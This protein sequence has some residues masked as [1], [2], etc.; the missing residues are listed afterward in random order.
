M[1]KI[2]AIGV[3]T[4]LGGVAA[5]QLALVLGAPWGAHVYG[6]RVAGPGEAL[7]APYRVASV[8][9]IGLLVGAG[10][11]VLARAGVVAPDL[12]ASALVLRGTWVVAVYLVLNTLANL[13][14]T[15]LVERWALGAATAA[16]AVMTVLVARS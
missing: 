6:G 4:I 7:P 5:M 16:A 1:E 11:L 15:S 9:A 12:A 13:A 3:T 2:A 10:W 14:S 8:V